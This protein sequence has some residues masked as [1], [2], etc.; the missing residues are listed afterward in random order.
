[1][2]PHEVSRRDGSR[3]LQRHP[4]VSCS[5]FIA[6]AIARTT[7]VIDAPSRAIQKGSATR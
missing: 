6:R 3:T 1:V 2:G 7:A 5:P 4:P